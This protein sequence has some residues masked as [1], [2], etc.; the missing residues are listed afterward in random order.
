MQR[1][2]APVKSPGDPGGDINKMLASYLSTKHEAAFLLKRPDLIRPVIP[3]VKDHAGTCCL[4]E[5]GIV[6]HQ[7]ACLVLNNVPATNRD[8][9]P[10]LRVIL[11]SRSLYQRG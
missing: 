7:A 5:V 9:P 2:F 4:A 10:E 8:Q 11:R 6:N 3:R 1:H